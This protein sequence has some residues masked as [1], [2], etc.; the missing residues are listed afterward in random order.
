M[1]ETPIL[2]S[3]A[4]MRKGQ[5]GASAE[6]G[7]TPE[8]SATIASIGGQILTDPQAFTWASSALSDKRGHAL[9]S[10]TAG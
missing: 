2:K 5:V 4:M 7:I 9:D 1:T 3:G 6:D 8:I 10:H